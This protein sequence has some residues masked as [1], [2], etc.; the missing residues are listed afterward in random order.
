[1]NTMSSAMRKSERDQFIEDLVEQQGLME[2]E[3]CYYPVK[4]LDAKW[5]F[6]RYDV[7]I[8]PLFGRGSRWTNLSKVELGKVM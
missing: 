5:V 8:T 4:I 1:M 6:G 3:G 7:E 2:H